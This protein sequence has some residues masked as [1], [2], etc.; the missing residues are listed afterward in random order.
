MLEWKPVSSGVRPV[1]S[2]VATPSVWA[3]TSV[4]ALALVTA[5]N[6][7][8]GHSDPGVDLLAI[9]VVVAL[10]STGARLAAAPGTA[11]LCWLALNG[12]ATAPLGEI[13]W[14][15][16]YDVA[17]IAC[18]LAAATAGTVLARLLHARAAYRRLT[19]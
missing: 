12:F 6:F 5:F 11:F 15:A 1:P 14:E 8:D 18:L 2:A 10:V 16:S 13:T 9:S 3:V 17:R 19:P 4:V 7:L